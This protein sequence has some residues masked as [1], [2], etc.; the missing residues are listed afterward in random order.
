MGKT[1]NVNSTIST[2]C[3]NYLVHSNGTIITTKASGIPGVHCTR[4]GIVTGIYWQRQGLSGPIPSG[5]A[6]LQ[7]LVDL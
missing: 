6:H 4:T 7:N 2:N 1:T 5:I 3:C